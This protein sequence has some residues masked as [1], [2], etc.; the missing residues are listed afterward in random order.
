MAWPIFH[1][2]RRFYLRET[3]K[4]D[5]EEDKAEEIAEELEKP[6]LLALQHHKLDS[7]EAA[8]RM[9]QKIHRGNAARREVA[10]MHWHENEYANCG[11]DEPPQIAVPSAGCIAQSLN[12]PP[13]N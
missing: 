3:G 5:W 4:R 12:A 11:D 2:V 8:A 1:C 7:E 6:V 13:P 10:E 9:I